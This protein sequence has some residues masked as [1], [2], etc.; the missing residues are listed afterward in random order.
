MQIIRGF[1]RHLVVGGGKSGQG[2]RN[3]HVIKL[4]HTV[5]CHIFFV[6]ELLVIPMGYKYELRVVVLDK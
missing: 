5:V 3:L 4:A 1:G 6:P 2:W